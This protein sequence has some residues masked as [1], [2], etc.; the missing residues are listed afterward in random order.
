[1]V[2]SYKLPDH[3]MIA[4]VAHTGWNNDP[5]ATARDSLSR[6]PDGRVRTAECATRR[7]RVWK[8]L[9]RRSPWLAPLFALVFLAAGNP[10]CTTGVPRPAK[11]A[12]APGRRRPE[13]GRCGC[14]RGSEG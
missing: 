6:R 3:F 12:H 7:E 9:H 13:R 1:V 2:R 10:F 4:V 14:G 5:D 11:S 8:W